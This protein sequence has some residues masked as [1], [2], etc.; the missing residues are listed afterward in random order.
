[1]PRTKDWGQRRACSYILPFFFSFVLRLQIVVCVRAT[2]LFFPR[3]T[4]HPRIIG[5][6]AFQI[7]PPPPLQR[8]NPCFIPTST[9]RF[10]PGS[11]RRVAQNSPERRLNAEHLR[12]SSAAYKPTRYVAFSWH[13]CKK[14]HNSNGC[15]IQY[16]WSV[17]KTHI[18]DSLL[19][20]LEPSMGHYFPRKKTVASKITDAHV[21]ILIF[22]VLP[23]FSFLLCPISHRTIFYH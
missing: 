10:R 9:F 1:M 4:S 16:Y 18:L 21:R 7:S 11:C 12:P 8:M 20:F 13:G 22:E 14:Y 19:R 15:I 6:P 3:C 23:N 17:I 2:S 5:L